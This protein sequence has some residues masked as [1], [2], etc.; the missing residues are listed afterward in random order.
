MFRKILLTGCISILSLP[1]LC[2]VAWAGADLAVLTSRHQTAGNANVAI[3]VPAELAGASMQI[4][5]QRWSDHFG[6]PNGCDGAVH[7]IATAATGEVYLG[8]AFYSCATVAAS[9]L[10]RYDPGSG[11]WSALDSGSG[12]GVNGPV[13]AL[14][15]DGKSLY[16]AGQFDQVNLGAPIDAA[17]V[18]RFDLQTLQWSALS[19]AS[20]NGVDG[21]AWALAQA[22]DGHLY[23]GGQFDQANVG[24]PI[25]AEGVARWDP[26]AQ[27]WSAPGG[28]G[29][30]PANIEA[31]ALLWH[32]GQLYAGS[33]QGV[34]VWNAQ[35]GWA[36]L[37]AGPGGPI[38][39]LAASA[40]DLYAGGI[41]FEVYPGDNTTI[42]SGGIAR[43][44]FI[45]Q[46]WNGVGEGL[47]RTF[48]EA[49]D[50]RALEIFEGRLVVG[51]WFFGTAGDEPLAAG[52]LVAWDLTS[53][54]WHT[55]DGVTGSGAGQLRA[56][57]SQGADLL[58]GGRF[59]AAGSPQQAAQSRNFAIWRSD[60]QQWVAPAAGNGA[61][62]IGPVYSLEA[63]DAKLYASGSITQ[64]G[65]LALSSLAS[66][67]GSTWDRVGTAQNEGGFEILAMHQAHGRLYM[68][69]YFGSASGPGQLPGLHMVSWDPVTGDWAVMGQFESEPPKASFIQ[70]Y[71]LASI[72]DEVFA[73]GTFGNVSNQHGTVVTTNIAR[74]NRV[75]GQ[76]SALGSDGGEGVWGTVRA[77]LA[78]DDDLY[79]GGN[80]SSANLGPSPIT[81]TGVARWDGLEWNA[82]V[83]AT[84]QQGAGTVST[85]VSDGTYLYLG[86]GFTSVGS[87]QV[88]AL[89]V[90]RWK[91]DGSGWET[92]G[93]GIG[94]LPG[95]GGN[96]DYV[97]ELLLDGNWLYA[98][99]SFPTAEN[100]SVVVNHIARWNLS[101]G[102]WRPLGSGLA[103]GQVFAREMAML[104]DEL[105]VAG[106]FQ[107]AGNRS[108]YNFASYHT[109]GDLSLTIN[110]SGGGRVLSQPAG[111]DCTANCSARF[112][113]DQTITLTA[114]PFASS[115]FVGW[116]GDCS[117]TGPCVV[118]FDRA[119]FV[120]AEF[121]SDAD[122][123]ANDFE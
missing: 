17:N 79:V 121:E 93:G 16:V 45:E 51:G 61:P 27:S 29:L 113:W 8:G 25:P 21:P 71:A 28:P 115:R 33:S 63:L 91:L 35:S 1:W 90:A 19:S 54:S 72:G 83:S 64:A 76:W 44:S 65:D 84:G 22:D 43:W 95:Q 77:L 24:S 67:D 26:I 56:I 87:G 88:P 31:Y 50:V 114:Q 60:E 123:F 86:G 96:T 39:A 38:F 62:V 5:D 58:L 81:A 80:F 59:A 66:W 10:I 55:L 108:A 105:H 36:R 37:P 47:E 122:L 14:T 7:A 73:A 99:G 13:L 9:N 30:L 49:P 32:Q 23:V 4:E 82:L 112:E 48:S 42:D 6:L 98:S 40:T 111:I 110:G 75:S 109:R 69:G 92:I 116:S 101:G 85:L 34:Q 2:A 46:R 107:M 103:G 78:V 52:G 15:I 57:E 41:W 118:D 20:G 89:R 18:A 120:G 11:S 12:Q 97:H 100:G 53:R 106:T 117:G 119:R 102:P 94:R 74:W 104:G 3:P 68:T 70:V